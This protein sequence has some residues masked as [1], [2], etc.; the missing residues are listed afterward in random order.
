MK[1][2]YF[3]ALPKLPS[4]VKLLPM[5]LQPA[6]SVGIILQYAYMVYFITSMTS[7]WLDLV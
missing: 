6:P 3:Q 1:H 4:E 5:H 7:E 2:I